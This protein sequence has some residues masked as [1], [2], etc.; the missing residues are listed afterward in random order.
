MSFLSGLTGGG[1]LFNIAEAAAL[2]AVTGGASLAVELG[3]Q[4]VL[5][6]A[7]GEGLQLVGQQLGLSQGDISS[8]LEE[9]GFGGQSGA[10]DTASA[11]GQ[12]LG[13]TPF[14]QGSV[15]GIAQQATDAITQMMQQGVAEASQGAEHSGAAHGKGGMSVLQ[16]IA[17]AMGKAMDDKLNDM[18]DKAQQLGNSQSGSSQ[19][20]Q[21][22]SE[23]QAD[24]QELSML[25]SAVANA[26]KSIGEAGS[27]LAKKD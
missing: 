21:L 19:Y 13:F 26:I 17:Y 7:V 27:T 5:K 20:G 22:S 18:A 3:A 11:I 10:A 25:S 2:G 4:Q 12:Q 24:G 16:A 15:S 14:E 23:I 6:S 1:N 9:T 8:V